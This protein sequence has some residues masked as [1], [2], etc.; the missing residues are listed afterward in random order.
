MK[1]AII[2]YTKDEECHWVAKLECG[3]YQ[4]VRHQ[5]PFISRPW[6]MSLEGRKSMLGHLLLCKKCDNREVKDFDE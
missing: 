5:P 2:G 3:H 6:V 1:Q 4:H